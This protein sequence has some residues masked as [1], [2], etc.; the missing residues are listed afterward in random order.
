[1]SNILPR[2]PI[3]LFLDLGL[4]LN[5]HLAQFFHHSGSLCVAWNGQDGLGLSLELIELG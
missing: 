4:H 1:M 3:Q 5:V 2:Q